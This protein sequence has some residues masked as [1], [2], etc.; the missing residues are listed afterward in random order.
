MG[1]IPL[2]VVMNVNGTVHRSY[3]FLPMRSDILLCHMIVVCRELNGRYINVCEF[4]L[5]VAAGRQNLT[6]NL[7]CVA[8]I[9]MGLSGNTRRNPWTGAW[10]KVTMAK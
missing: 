7:G 5:V 2:H 8:R 6:C 9:S 4:P 3:V 1:S 10:K